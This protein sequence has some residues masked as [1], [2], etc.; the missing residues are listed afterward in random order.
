M[1]SLLGLAEDGKRITRYHILKWRTVEGKS[2]YVG[3]TQSQ[4]EEN[5]KTVLAFLINNF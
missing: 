5:I 3:L 1:S 4:S 2:F